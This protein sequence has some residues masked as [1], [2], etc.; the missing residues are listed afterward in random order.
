MKYVIVGSGPCG[1]SL[2]YTLVQNGH[3]VELIERDEM[4]GGSWNS[5]WIEDKYWSENSPRVIPKHLLTT[6]H[7]MDFLNEIGMYDADFSHVY[8][9]LPTTI[10]KLSGFFMNNLSLMDSIQFT[11]AVGRYSLFDSDKTLQE[12]L[13]TTTITK[14]GKKAIK[15]FSILS[16]AH[17]RDTHVNDFFASFASIPPPNLL[18][19]REPNKWHELVET[20]IKN[21]AQI[22][23]N[24]EVIRI[25]SNESRITDITTTNKKTGEVVIHK[26]DR[27]I[28]AIPPSCPHNTCK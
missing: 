25:N 3:H 14:K 13:D 6:N 17:P 4:L 11:L 20:K 28:L 23:K 7:F 8:G 1:L 5:Q 19:F 27:F 26:A 12:W 15:I 22:F 9:T 21:K 18:Q 2:A 24:T 16:N 10:S